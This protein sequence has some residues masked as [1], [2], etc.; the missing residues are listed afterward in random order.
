MVY[1]GCAIWFLLGVN[2][3]FEELEAVLELL[4]DPHTPL[5]IVNSAFCRSQTKDGSVIKR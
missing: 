2:L 1:T 5:M 4:A 3:I